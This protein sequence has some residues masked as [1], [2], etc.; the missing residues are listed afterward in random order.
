[1]SKS[2]ISKTSQSCKKDAVSVTKCVQIYS[3][4][5]GGF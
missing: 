1:M 3:I 5:S 4:H 2:F